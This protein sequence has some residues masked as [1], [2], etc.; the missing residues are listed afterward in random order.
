M[1]TVEFIS[2][3]KVLSTILKDNYESRGISVENMFREAYEL[4][5]KPDFNF[6]VH[7]GDWPEFYKDKKT[8][9]FS[10]T[11]KKYEET[12]P[13]FLFD[14]WPEIGVAS[15]NK[16]VDSMIKAGNS[17]PTYSKIGWIGALTSGVRREMIELSKTDNLIH[18]TEF[19]P[20]N[21]NRVDPSMLYKNTPSYLSLEDQVKRWRY[22]IDAE[23]CGWSARLKMFLFSNRVTFLIDRP[24]EEYWFPK[25]KP[26]VH[27]VPV[28]RDLSDLEKNLKK[29]LSDPNL[30][31]QIKAQ[32]L[33]FA[34]NNLKREH[35]VEYYK[36][37]ISRFE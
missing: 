4:S 7:T 33:E 5:S 23:G 36:E 9:C 17:T 24:F 18:H 31:N 1:A 34:N 35:A 16:T 32:A 15:Y 20:M 12:V 30:E 21:W 29:L 25:L 26:W 2:K 11:T 28:K 10:T 19:I 8:F 14:M 13:D 3:N 6:I 22:L 27:Y 37:I